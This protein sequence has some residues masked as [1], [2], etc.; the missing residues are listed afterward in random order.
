MEY[1]FLLERPVDVERL[2]AKGVKA[3]VMFHHLEGEAQQS[4]DYCKENGVE[5]LCFQYDHWNEQVAHLCAA[6]QIKCA[7]L[8]TD[9]TQKM[10]SALQSGAAL[11]GSYCYDVH[12]FER[13][14]NNEENH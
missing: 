8:H 4:I 9:R 7:V 6:A 1:I 5:Y 14:L 2:R 13:L 11:V 3:A 10:I 12:Y